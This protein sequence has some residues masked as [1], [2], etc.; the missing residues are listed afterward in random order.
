MVGELQGGANGIRELE[1][2]RVAVAVDP[3]HQP[4][5]G[6]GGVAAV[7]EQLTVAS[8]VVLGLVLLEGMHKVFEV[9]AGKVMACSGLLQAHEHGVVGLAAL[10]CGQLLAPPSEQV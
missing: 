7:L 8:I 2:V 5:D 4:A 1:E 9:L 10:H 3:Q 6:V